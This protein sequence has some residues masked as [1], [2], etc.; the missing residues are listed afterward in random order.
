[1]AGTTR[2][3]TREC[4]DSSRFLSPLSS[5]FSE[6]VLIVLLYIHAL[7]SYLVHK[8]ACHRKLPPPCILCSKFDRRRPDFYRGLFCNAHQL[9]I[10][11]LTYCRVH[12]R[13]ADGHDMCKACLLSFVGKVK[14]TN[15][16]LG[17]NKLK[18]FC[19]CC[20]VSIKNR[21]KAIYNG[22]DSRF[23]RLSK[24]GRNELKSEMETE[25]PFSGVGDVKEDLLSRCLEAAPMASVQEKLIQT[26]SV[27]PNISISVPERKI[28]ADVSHGLEETIWNQVEVK[29]NI[30]VSSDIVIE[31]VPAEALITK[32]DVP[33]SNGDSV[34]ASNSSDIASRT[35]QIMNERLSSI[36]APL[37][38]PASCDLLAARESSIVPEDIKSRLSQISSSRWLDFPWNDNFTPKANGQG[39]ESKLSDAKRSSVDRN[40]SVVEYLDGSFISEIEGESLEDRLKRQIEQDRKLM[41]VLYRELEEERNASEISANEAMSMINRLQEEKATIQME[42]LQYLRMMEEQTEYDQEALQKLNEL[43][44]ERDKDIIDLASMV[45]SYRK[46]FGGKPLMSRDSEEQ[47]DCEEK[48]NTENSVS[49]PCFMRPGGC[50]NGKTLMRNTVL[51]FEDEKVHISECLKKLER[52]L[53]LVSSSGAFAAESELYREPILEEDDEGPFSI[54]VALRES[55]LRSLS[56]NGRQFMGGQR[57]DIAS[58]GN[59]ISQLNVRLEA[60][61][62]DRSFL[63]HA[64][65]SLRNGSSGIQFV[66][67]IACHLRELRKI[68]IT[69]PRA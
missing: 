31:Q 18:K 47:F 38:S 54:K 61:E 32:F 8:F 21:S 24:I 58:L 55:R 5:A 16:G 11:S 19:S 52:K 26:P 39:D 43:L 20:S 59:E 15:I 56:S 9:E 36:K 48:E 1:M 2:N 27:M 66:Q 37:P 35:S 67:E 45:E 42:A 25:V 44:D 17:A 40:E 30:S 69:T 64:V 28:Q 13:L 3:F 53:K 29:P 46:Q 22:G 68:G 41:S 57:N 14:G 60:L 33:D 23:D 63:E 49:T 6:L 10:S 51:D 65:R 34:K 12:Q 62:E 50:E 4:I 7:L